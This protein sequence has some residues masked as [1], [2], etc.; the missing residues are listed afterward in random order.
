MEFSGVVV[1]VI[2]LVGVVAGAAI[3][4]L[5]ENRRVHRDR[6][7]KAQDARAAVYAE[8]LA[9]IVQWQHQITWSQDRI[10]ASGSSLDSRL[11]KVEHLKDAIDA[12]HQAALVPLFRL[13]MIGSAAVVR[14]S[15]EVMHLNYWYQERF[16]GGGLDPELRDQ[17]RGEWE[18]VRD[19]FLDAVRAEVGSPTAWSQ[20]L[21]DAADIRRR[22]VGSTPAR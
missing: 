19:P 10:D 4:S 20:I 22:E 18:L 13:R 6:S 17:F 16:L 3:T 5:A 9:S 21:A 1:G 12:A 15:Q 8:F 7:W 11:A 2:G 14:W